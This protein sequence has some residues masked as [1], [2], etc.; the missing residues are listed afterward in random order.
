MGLYSINENYV[1]VTLIPREIWC[2]HKHVVN[3]SAATSI[4]CPWYA[5]QSM[6]G[7]LGQPLL[8]FVPK[9]N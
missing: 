4:T 9:D 1:S 3:V 5:G 2:F 8:P 7:N 6:D